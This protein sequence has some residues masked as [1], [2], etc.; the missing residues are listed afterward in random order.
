MVLS[1]LY[2]TCSQTCI[3]NSLVLSVIITCNRTSFQISRQ[4]ML[5]NLRK[6]F[7]CT[8][9]LWV[10]M[11]SFYNLVH[12]WQLLWCFKNSSATA[13]SIFSN[14]Q[15]IFQQIYALCVITHFTSACTFFQTANHTIFYWELVYIVL[16]IGYQ[17]L[18]NNF[19][20]LH[21]I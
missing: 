8:Y 10:T 14:F 4:T 13:W 2:N 7:K 19:C 15:Q 20:F 11:F 6:M 18:E 9:K 5:I 21:I 16:R 12:F 1:I 17:F 3:V